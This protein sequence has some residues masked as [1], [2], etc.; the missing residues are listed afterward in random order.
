VAK[1]IAFL[2]LEQKI[3]IFQRS[4]SS[5]YDIILFAPYALY[6]PNRAGFLGEVL[7]YIITA[8]LSRYLNG[9]RLL[10]AESGSMGAFKKTN[11]PSNY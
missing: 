6:M 5:G 1:I 11:C 8:G 10:E 7:H 9:I 2:E 4:P 3:C